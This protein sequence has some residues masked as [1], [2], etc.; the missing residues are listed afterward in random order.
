M[1]TKFK[2]LEEGDVFLYVYMD[3]EDTE[4]EDIEDGYDG[5]K[6]GIF[7]ATVLFEYSDS[8]DVK[9][10]RFNGG[11]IPEGQSEEFNLV[12]GDRDFQFL[13]II[14][15]NNKEF[16]RMKETYPEHYI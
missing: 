12:F 8:I 16:K 5:D 7:I 1:K 6:E 14:F 4:E 11:I 15:D 3:I 9:D 13:E 2:D 10:L